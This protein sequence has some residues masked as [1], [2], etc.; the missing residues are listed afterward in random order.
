M[1]TMINSIYRKKVNGCLGLRGGERTPGWQLKGIGFLLEIIMN[2]W[3]NEWM[4]EIK[5]FYM[6]VAMAVPIHEYA[7]N[8]QMDTV[9]GWIV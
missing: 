5:L 6:T 9:S 2:E 3:M 1:F 7:S 8:H 4:N